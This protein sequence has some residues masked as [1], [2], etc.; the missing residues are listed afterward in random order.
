MIKIDVFGYEF[1]VITSFCFYSFLYK[2]N[3]IQDYDFDTCNKLLQVIAQAIAKATQVQ[4]PKGF[5]QF[6]EKINK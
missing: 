6:E 3:D 1:K 5:P 4:S 2:A